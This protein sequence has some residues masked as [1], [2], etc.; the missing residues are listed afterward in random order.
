MFG[1]RSAG[2]K[3]VTQSK[4]GSQKASSTPEQS[5]EDKNASRIADNDP[6]AVDQSGS[7][8]GQSKEQ[9]LRAQSERREEILTEVV[10]RIDALLS[11]SVKMTPIR[12]KVL[13][14]YHPDRSGDIHVGWA[15]NWSIY[16]KGPMALTHGSV[17]DYDSHVPVVFAGYGLK[18]RTI[19]EKITT[20]DVAPTLATILSVRRPSGATGKVLDLR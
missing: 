2:S 12:Q 4:F 20:L 9:M 15:Q 13:L 14:N 18:G 11:N 1:Q 16:E 17:W 5:T 7:E 3:P 8:H 6:L 10:E 19:N